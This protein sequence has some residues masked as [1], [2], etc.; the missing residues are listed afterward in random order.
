MSGDNKLKEVYWSNL[1]LYSKVH[2]DMEGIPYVDLKKAGMKKERN[3][4]KPVALGI[5]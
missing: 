2:C 4:I 3:A 5:P 1:D